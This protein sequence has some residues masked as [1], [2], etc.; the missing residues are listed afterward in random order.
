MDREYEKTQLLTK[1]IVST[2]KKWM[3]LNYLKNQLT[4]EFRREGSE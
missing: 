1:K 4:Q 3:A 2:R